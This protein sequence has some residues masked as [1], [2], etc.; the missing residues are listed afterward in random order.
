[1]L[2]PPSSK[3]KTT[4]VKSMPVNLKEVK[5]NAIYSDQLSVVCSYIE[6]VDDTT[7]ITDALVYIRCIC[8]VFI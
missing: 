2:S 8:V 5:D 4:A 6:W 7:R 1:M 3:A